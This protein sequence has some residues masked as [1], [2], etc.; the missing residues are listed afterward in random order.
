[1]QAAKQLLSYKSSPLSLR[2]GIT[3]GWAEGHAVPERIF[4][5]HMKTYLKVYHTL[6]AYL[7]TQGVHIMSFNMI[8]HETTMVVSMNVF[9]YKPLYRTVQ[10]DRSKVFKPWTGWQ[11]RWSRAP[12]TLWRPRL[13]QSLTNERKILQDETNKEIDEYTQYMN[14]QNGAADMKMQAQAA[15]ETTAATTATMKAATRS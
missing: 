2:A 5:H 1:M 9:W 12:L 3:K 10:T 8:P 14:E 15:P 6:K 7:A 13:V 11:S 4:P